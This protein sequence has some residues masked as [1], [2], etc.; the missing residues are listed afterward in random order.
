MPQN[1]EDLIAEREETHGSYRHVSH[2]SQATKDLWHSQPG[3]HK[4]SPERKESLDTIAVKISRILNGD[5]DCEDHWKDI[6]GYAR[7]AR[8]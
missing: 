8:Q 3:W 1:I 6:E 4:L 2:L 5:P 7:L